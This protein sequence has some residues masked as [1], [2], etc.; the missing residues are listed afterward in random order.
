MNFTKRRGQRIAKA[1]STVVIHW[2]KAAT[3]VD[4]AVALGSLKLV[5]P[6]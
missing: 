5:S 4:K 6:L 3:T 2:R 1:N